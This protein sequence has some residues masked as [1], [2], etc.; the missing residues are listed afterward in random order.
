MLQDSGKREAIP[1]LL[2]FLDY[3][4]GP[5]TDHI[6]CCEKP[7]ICAAREALTRL[8]E[9]D[10]G[11]RYDVAVR[12]SR[13]TWCDYLLREW[14]IKLLQEIPH[15]AAIYSDAQCLLGRLTRQNEP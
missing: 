1:V 6:T 12:A 5:G 2:E 7:I 8:A 15:T 14:A 4:L 13:S 11:L 3:S 9:T 10:F